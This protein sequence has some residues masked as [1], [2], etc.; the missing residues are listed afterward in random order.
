MANRSRKPVP[1]TTDALD[2]AMEMAGDQ[3]AARTLLAKH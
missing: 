2:V 3:D 1:K